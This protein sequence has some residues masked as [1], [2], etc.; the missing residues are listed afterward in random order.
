MVTNLSLSDQMPDF[1]KETNKMYDE[2][3]I[4]FNLILVHAY[5]Y[6]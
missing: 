2:E 4:A 5:N 1:L 3:S 6:N